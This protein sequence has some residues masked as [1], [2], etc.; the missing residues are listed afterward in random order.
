MT[1]TSDDTAPSFETPRDSED[2]TAVGELPD[3]TSRHQPLNG[4]VAKLRNKEFALGAW[5]QVGDYH[6]AR[7]VGD[8]T[9]DFTVLDM[10]H[11]GFSFPDLGET[12]QWMLSR[13]NASTVPLPATPIVRIPP[14][15]SELN[16]WMVK[17]VLD[18][19]SFGVLNPHVTSGPQVTAAA[20]AMRYPGLAADGGVE[21]MR[22]TLPM[23]AMRYWGI[24]DIEQY[25]ARADLWPLVPDGDLI[26]SVLVESLSSWNNIDEIVATPGL[27]AVF[28]GPGDGSMTLGLRDFNI[29][30]ERLT[31]HRQRVIAACKAAGVPVGTP[32]ATDPFAAIEEGFDFLVLPNWDEALAAELR[33]HAARIRSKA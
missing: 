30:D 13:R 27:G 12:L 20:S 29:S 21:G 10:E 32:G 2:A 28:W 26:L 17:Q 19:G 31:P 7:E 6:Q 22:G 8:S 33:G 14:N 1:R 23:A 11:V 4:L 24:S 9:A 3:S 25:F 18:Y 15:G 5:V 16:Q